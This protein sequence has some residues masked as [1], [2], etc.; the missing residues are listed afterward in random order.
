MIN[1]KVKYLYLKE[2]NFA[3]RFGFC[4]RSSAIFY[5]PGKSVKTKIILNKIC[6][7]D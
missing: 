5:I 6:M 4:I 1:N 7:L 2:D 3:K